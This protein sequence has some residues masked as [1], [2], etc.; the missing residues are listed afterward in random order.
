MAR[1]LSSQ[2]FIALACLEFCTSSISAALENVAGKIVVPHTLRADVSSEQAVTIFSEGSLSMDPSARLQWSEA[3]GS[4]VVW[5]DLN[6]ITLAG[7]F[8]D[9][10][11]SAFRFYRVQ[12]AGS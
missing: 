11:N 2:C 12:Q 4:N 5:R 1:N 8:T 10:P 6:G 3:E 9:R 7:T